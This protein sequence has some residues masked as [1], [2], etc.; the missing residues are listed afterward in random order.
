MIA[1]RSDPPEIEL[2]LPDSGEEG[3]V[4]DFTPHIAGRGVEA[5]HPVTRNGVAVTIL[6]RTGV[7]IRV[8]VEADGRLRTRRL[9][10]TF[11]LKLRN[12]TLWQRKYPQTKPSKI[13]RALPK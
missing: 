10:A 7:A 3:N 9:A 4:R 11:K 8:G 6:T 12:N 1:A 2:R 5:V 13:R